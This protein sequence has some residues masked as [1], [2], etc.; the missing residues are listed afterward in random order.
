MQFN[1]DGA[2]LGSPLTGAGPIYTISWNTTG[3]ANGPHTL[4]A[5][6]SDAA[7]NTATSSVSVIVDSIP[8]V[9]S[10]TAPANNANVTGTV[11][12]TANATDNVAVASVQFSLDGA[13]LGSPLT[14][15]GP[16]YTT[17]WNTT[18]VANGTHTL[19]AV[20]TD[21]AGNTASSS[22][23][24][25]I[26]SNT[27][28]VAITVPANNAAVTGTVT[29]TA[30]AVD[31]L[32]IASVQFK[33]DGAPLGSPVS[34]PGPFYSMSWNTAGV[35]SGTHSI[36]AVATDNSNNT[37]SSSISVVVDSTPPVI[38]ITAPANNAL[39][40]A[41][42][43][44]T[45]TANA[46]DNVAVAS[47]QFKLDGAPLGALLTGAGPNY[48]TSWNTTGVVNGTHT[49][50]AVATDMPATPPPPRSHW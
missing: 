8:P 13:P 21:A 34:G 41:N 17:S 16:S 46:T 44:V 22:I 25:T 27:P 9:V 47:V 26:S 38:S 7:G 6:A 24:V 1:L 2:A 42:A 20:A 29:L 32:G 48:S 12:V 39:F 14:G 40:G 45:L 30:N 4:S 19:S 28:T 23:S 43:T 11:T 3:V 33:L 5:V 10:I 15:A 37:A 36:S 18:G 35:T 31:N 49:L 50:S